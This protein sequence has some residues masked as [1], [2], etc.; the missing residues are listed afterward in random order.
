MSGRLK[1]DKCLV[2]V[3]VLASQTEKNTIGSKWSNRV[4]CDRGMNENL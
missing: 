2:M 4:H 1:L 3:R